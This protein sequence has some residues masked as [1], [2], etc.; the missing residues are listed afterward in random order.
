M[1]LKLGEWDTTMAITG[2]IMITLFTGIPDFGM[3][4]NLDL[5]QVKKITLIIFGT[6]F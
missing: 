6:T 3:S 2:D 4:M 1:S 5:L